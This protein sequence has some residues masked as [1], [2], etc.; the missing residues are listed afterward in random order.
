MW[1]YLTPSASKNFSEVPAIESARSFKGT[2]SSRPSRVERILDPHIPGAAAR[3]RAE[4]VDR[5][6]SGTDEGGCHATV[7]EQVHHAIDGVPLR[8]AAEV[9]LDARSIESNGSRGRIQ[10]DV[11]RSHMLPRRGEIRLR[12]N[13]PVAVEEAPRP[14]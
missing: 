13:V 8:D 9:E 11:Y 14:S 10:D 1:E 4:T 3:R 2:V 7:P 6:A 12:W 5:A